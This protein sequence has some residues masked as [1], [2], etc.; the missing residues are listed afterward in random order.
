MREKA[1]RGFA[2]C[3][4]LTARNVAFARFWSALR[5]KCSEGALG[6]KELPLEEGISEYLYASEDDDMP[7]AK[8]Q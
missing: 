2:F 3:P 8:E 6:P 5:D 7:R 1:H 4:A